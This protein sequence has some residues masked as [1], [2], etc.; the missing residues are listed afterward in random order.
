MPVADKLAD[1]K[2]HRRRSSDPDKQ[3]QNND[4]QEGH[5]RV[6]RDAEGAMIRIGIERMCKGHVDNREQQEHNKAHSNRRPQRS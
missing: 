5:N 6:H 1:F 4:H 2:Q 3:I